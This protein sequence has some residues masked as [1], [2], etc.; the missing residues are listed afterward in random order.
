MGCSEAL[1]CI[2]IEDCSRDFKNRAAR[3]YRFVEGLEAQ[4]LHLGKT[5]RLSYL[6]VQNRVISEWSLGCM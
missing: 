4:S 3:R 5:T 6:K 1:V 2:S